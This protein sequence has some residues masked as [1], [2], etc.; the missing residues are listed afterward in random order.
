MK[1]HNIVFFI[2]PH[3][4]FP[5]GTTGTIVHVYEGGKAVEVE[6]LEDDVSIVSTVEADK[7]HET[8]WTHQE[9]EA[10]KK[11][12]AMLKSGEITVDDIRDARKELEK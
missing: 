10:A 5:F 1:E 2:K 6:V 7:L 9:V 12:V 4:H 8:G 3:L 11:L